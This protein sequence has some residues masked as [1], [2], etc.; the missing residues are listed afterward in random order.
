MNISQFRTHIVKPVLKYLEMDSLNA[1][2]LLI[3][4]AVHES[5]NLEYV[6]Q[7][8]GGPALS[9][10]QIEP[11]THKDVWDNYIN[12]RPDLM[13][14]MSRLRFDAFKGQE[15]ELIGNIP[16][17]TAIARII[18]RRARGRL[19]DKSDIMGMAKYWKSNYNT[20]KGKGR[21]D[22]F[23]NNYKRYVLEDQNG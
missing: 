4:T 8:G 5:K 12:Y 6:R 11:A 22:D 19:P 16:Y 18:Y 2:E 17:A 3:A 14:K 20:F 1:E 13:R 7:L 21:V 9:I 23:V 15:L 10:F